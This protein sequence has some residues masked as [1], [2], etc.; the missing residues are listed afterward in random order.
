MKCFGK[1]ITTSI[2]VELDKTIK[3][4]NY[5]CFIPISYKSITNNSKGKIVG[6]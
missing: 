1:E 6:R 5:F 2:N 4:I 3:T